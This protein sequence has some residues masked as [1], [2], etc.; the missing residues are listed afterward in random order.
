MPQAPTVALP[1]R[2]PLVI[3][4]GNRASSTTTDARLVNCYVEKGTEEGDYRL[5]KRPGLLESATYSETGAGQGIFNWNGDIF[6]VFGTSLF[7]NGTS[8]GTVDA[9]GGVYSFSINNQSAPAKMQLGNG[10][11][12]YNYD[13]AGG[14]VEIVDVDFIKPFVK[15][16]VYL[17]STTYYMTSD[18]AIR[19]SDLGDPTAF[20]ALNKIIAQIEPDAGVYLAKQLV[21]VVVFKQWTTEAFYDA[22]NATGSPLGAVQGAKVNYGCA[23]ADSVQDVDGV[24]AWL[25]SSRAASLQVFAM[26]NL[27]AQV[28]ST[29]AVDRL[30]D[31]ADTSLVYSWQFKQ[32]GHRF[33][34]LTLPNNN[35]TLVYDFSESLWHQ[36]TDS[37]GNYFPIIAATRKSDT[38]QLFQHATNG[39]VYLVDDDYVTDD[40]ALITVDI[41]P[42]PFDGGTQ[43][44]KTLSM[45]GFVGD[46]TAGSMLR[47]RNSD[48]DYQT[49]SNF[50]E[51]NLSNKRPLLSACG[52]FVRRAF[53]FRHQAATRL[54]LRAIELQLDIGTL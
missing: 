24:L 19:G 51:V 49:W 53:H 54:R 13:A 52:T 16:L 46:Q 18:G 5:Y 48:D 35:L 4:P 31:G 45:M 39:K 37:S 29:K 22:G 33:Y 1:R 14:L 41:Y 2:L 28:I 40:G 10:V 42:P 25:G 27:K 8:V 6:T 11:K 3:T 23:S 36:W 47:I 12:A 38:Q 21:Y 44:R 50:R 30:L 15:G 26:D 43:R 9:T 7:K 17:D 32:R 20:D 34:G